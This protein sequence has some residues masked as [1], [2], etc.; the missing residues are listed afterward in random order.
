MTI[1]SV[2]SSEL[3]VGAF[4]LARSSEHNAEPRLG[5]EADLSNVRN[6]WK[7]AI[8]ADAVCQVEARTTRPPRLNS[9]AEGLEA[10]SLRRLAAL[11]WNPLV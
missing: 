9:V 4:Q 11:A 8:E 10:T 5:R 6:G 7:A 1:G 2:G 3:A